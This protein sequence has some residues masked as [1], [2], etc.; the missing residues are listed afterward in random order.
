M[1]FTTIISCGSSIVS[2]ASN[3]QMQAALNSRGILISKSAIE[4][5]ILGRIFCS[6]LGLFGCFLGWRDLLA[7]VSNGLLRHCVIQRLFLFFTTFGGYIELVA[8]FSLTQ[9]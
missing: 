4:V 7:V 6:I 5:A 3:W 1:I 8:V 9:I 2:T